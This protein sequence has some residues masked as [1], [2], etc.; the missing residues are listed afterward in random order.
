M[1]KLEINSQYPLTRSIERIN[2]RILSM[3]AQEFRVNLLNL[4]FQL[5]KELVYRI[6]CASQQANARESLDEN[7]KFLKNE[8]YSF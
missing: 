5:D 6:H 8:I 4:V 1:T 3:S 7:N 2:H